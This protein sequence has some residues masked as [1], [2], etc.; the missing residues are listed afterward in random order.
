MEEQATV[1]R[2]LKDTGFLYAEGRAVFISPYSGSR[3][4]TLTSVEE[5]K[6]EETQ[7]S[8]HINATGLPTSCV[9]CTV[10]IAIIQTYLLL[11][12]TVSTTD[13]YDSALKF[14]LQDALT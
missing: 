8:L 7:H 2:Q 12:S 11:L 6:D 1:N 5:A 14:S 3:S 13:A 10:A 9:G 4:R